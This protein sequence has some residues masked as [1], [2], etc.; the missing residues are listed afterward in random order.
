MITNKTI[1]RLIRFDGG[2]LPVL[3]LYTGLDVDVSD[4]VRL[5]AHLKGLVQQVEP[6]TEDESLGHEA[7]VSLREDLGR[8]LETQGMRQRPPGTL[9]IFACHGAG[10]YEEVRLPRKV[11]DR[12]RT[13]VTP[14]VRPMLAVL[15]EY[16][17]TCIVVI[18]KQVA[19]VWELFLNE[20]REVA[21]VRDKALR[22]SDY[23]GWYGLQEYGVRNK[24]DDLTKRHYRRVVGVLDQLF[25]TGDHDLLAVGGHDEEIPP[26]LD[27]LPHRLRPKLAG[28]FQIDADSATLGDIQQQ[29]HQIVDQYE[30]DEERQLVAD[31][32]DRAASGGR[33]TV[34]LQH[35]LWAGSVAAIEKLLVQD[36]VVIEGVVCDES[37]WLGLSG[38]TCPFC[39]KPTRRTTDV[40]NELA[41]T[42]IDESG[43]VEH[44]RADTPLK[45]QVAAATLRFPLPPQQTAAG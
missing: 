21:V 8:I 45:E 3:S 14:W 32:F 22:K 12:V 13:D 29:A 34:G 17:R 24:A 43:T 39:G 28:T 19:R 20:I 9:A 42:V 30:R 15:D 37:G 6:L 23:A 11:R 35:C 16:H 10:L 38:E 33:A 1:D 36:G 41:E 26:F 2:G 7:R 5:R 18:E 31:V 44:V 40:L 27:F 4:R 25:R